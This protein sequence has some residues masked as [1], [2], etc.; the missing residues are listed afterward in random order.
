MKSRKRKIFITFLVAPTEVV[1]CTHNVP[2]R[3]Y[4][5]PVICWRACTLHLAAPEIGRHT[6]HASVG[7][8]ARLSMATRCSMSLQEVYIVKIG[9]VCNHIVEQRPVAICAMAIGVRLHLAHYIIII[10]ASNKKQTTASCRCVSFNRST[11]KSVD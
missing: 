10:I 11:A 6:C 9:S 3:Q 4:Q 5:V 1:K 8:H 7:R 2:A